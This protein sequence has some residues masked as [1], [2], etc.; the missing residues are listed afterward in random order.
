MNMLVESKRD[1]VF[2]RDPRRKQE[3]SHRHIANRIYRMIW[4]DEITI[5]RQGNE[6]W[7]T[8]WDVLDS[9]FGID[10]IVQFP[11]GLRLTGQEKFLSHKHRSWRTITVAYKNQNTGFP[12]SWFKLAC[13]FYLVGYI[14]S[15]G[16]GFDPWIIVD[17]PRAVVATHEER[18]KWELQGQNDPSYEATFLYTKMDA[19]PRDC[20]IASNLE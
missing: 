2:E 9:S 13:Q 10:V 12:L 6:G 18:I 7:P 4:G 19:L 5:I 1:L 11:D 14:N 16:N 20:I 8:E 3:L 15:V 17:W